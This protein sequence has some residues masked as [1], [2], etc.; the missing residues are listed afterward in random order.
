MGTITTQQHV[1]PDSSVCDTGLV[2]CKLKSRR[3]PVSC[4]VSFVFSEPVYL[5]LRSGVD[6]RETLYF[7]FLL[8]KENVSAQYMGKNNP[9]VSFILYFGLYIFDGLLRFFG[10]SFIQKKSHWFF[11]K[12]ITFLK[13]REK[14]YLRGFGGKKGRNAVIKLQSQK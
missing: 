6:P 12:K 9:N 4:L 2:L 14:G 1:R 5:N 7:F 11:L 10:S 13:E 8:R 3:A